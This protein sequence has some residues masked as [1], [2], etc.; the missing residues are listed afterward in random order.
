MLSENILLTSARKLAG[1]PLPLKESAQRIQQWVERNILVRSQN[2][3]NNSQG[4]IGFHLQNGSGLGPYNTLTPQQLLDVL[5]FAHAKDYGGKS[6][7]SL[8]PVSQLKGSLE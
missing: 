3:L 1:R 8:L 6:Y 2:P 4:L 5:L 7:F